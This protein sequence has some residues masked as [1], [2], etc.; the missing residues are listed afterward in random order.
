MRG[1]DDIVEL[2]LVLSATD[3]LDDGQIATSGY[4]SDD[5]IAEIE[6][7]GASVTIVKD[8]DELEA[9]LDSLFEIIEQS[10]P[11]VG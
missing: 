10:E 6:G 1:L 9:T 3:I 5:A 11:P 7:R 4:A 8:S 2:V